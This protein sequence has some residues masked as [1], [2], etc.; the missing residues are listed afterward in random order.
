MTGRRHLNE[1]AIAEACDLDPL[2]YVGRGQAL[3]AGPLGR[4]AR[5]RHSAP[6]FLA[7]LYGTFLLRIDGANWLSCRAAVVPA[8]ISYEFDM[9][10]EP[11]GVLY[12]EPNVAGVNSLTPLV[13]GARDVAGALVGS[14]GE[15]S[16][17][18]ML[19]E[20]RD[21]PRW[22]SAAV[23][24]LVAFTKRRASKDLDLRV[25]RVVADM[26]ERYDEITPV[27]EIA[28]SVGLSA[29]RFQHLFTRE[30][31]VPFRRYRAWHRLRAAIREVVNGSNLTHAAHAAGF[32]DQAHFSRA[33][34]CA[35]GASAYP[36]LSRV[37]RS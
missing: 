10:G 20:D 34:R 27:A 15:I 3:F 16:V 33:F 9:G 12:L 13:R 37:R 24:D 18:R 2:W 11:L 30:T 8:G 28:G 4:N 32:S 21:A 14:A 25:S 5:H 26:H 36:G 7:G 22:T 17:M 1:R 23:N 31:G 19:Y 29:S 6:V 35:F